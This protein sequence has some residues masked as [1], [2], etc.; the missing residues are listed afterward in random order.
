[1]ET[2]QIQLEF[3]SEYKKCKVGDIIEV[4]KPFKLECG[5]E[6]QSFPIAFKTYGKLNK[7]KS[8]AILIFHGLTADQYMAEIHPVT[9]KQGWWQY[10]VGEKKP[11]DTNKFFVIC[12]NLLGGCMGSLGPKTINPKTK[13]PYGISFPVITI[14]D[15]A[16]YAN[17]LLE[18]FGIT[19]LYA[20]IGASMGGM[21]A[22]EFLYLFP[23]KVQRII[24]ISTALKHTAQNI[25]FNE[26]SR[27][28]IL[29]DSEFKKG[30]YFEDKSFPTSGLGIA[31]MIAH[32]TYLSENS[33]DAKF[34]RT[35]QNKQTLGF[36]FDVDFKIESYLRYQGI[37]FINRFDPNSYLYLTRALDYFDL[38]SDLKKEKYGPCDNTIKM[39]VVSFSDDW[40]FPTI[41]AKQI[42][43]AF[44]ASFE[45]F[46][47]N[48]I[49]FV[50]IQSDKG[51]DSFLLENTQF[52]KAIK[53]FLK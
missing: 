13:K 7:D 32:I 45:R 22:L 20:L 8:N 36:G 1:M 43:K 41:Q 42:V 51:H 19:N 49:G 48:K 26:V 11:I 28:A 12:P 9:K 30:R 18:E 31:R 16:V 38:E 33:L 23:Q 15:M 53:G 50:E 24:A 3:G 2:K 5:A 21:V 14:K 10:M 27:Q 47:V 44:S 40:L 25:A 17:F 39:L 37:T 34:G 52:E 35:L 6:F 29:S 4:Q 46:N